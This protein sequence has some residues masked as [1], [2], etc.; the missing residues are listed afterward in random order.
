LPC[1]I[2]TAANLCCPLY[3]ILNMLN[4]SRTTVF[5]RNK[6]LGLKGF[7]Q[8]TLMKEIDI[9][10]IRLNQRKNSTK[11]GKNSLKQSNQYLGCVCDLVWNLKAVQKSLVSWFSSGLS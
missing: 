10:E 6:I 8:S 4:Y 7:R 2:V 11:S 9:K 5:A 3:V 1:N